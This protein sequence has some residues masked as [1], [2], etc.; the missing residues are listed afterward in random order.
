MLRLP[1]AFVLLF[2][3][4]LTDDESALTALDKLA[5]AGEINERAPLI[6][7]VQIQIAAPPDRVWIKLTD[8]PDWP[9]WGPEI[10]SASADMPL[11]LGSHLAWQVGGLTIHARIQLCEAGHRLAWT[12]VAMT[13]RAVHVWELRPA[14]GNQT[15]VTVNES[16]E[17]P[18]MRL[19]YSSKK[20]ARADE[21][22]LQA[23]K[24]AS[25][26]GTVR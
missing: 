9:K 16:M 25:E 21:D 3:L 26:D 24:R 2:C 19:L 4:A 8:V 17:G 18:M 7:H 5:A 22:W 6:S 15:L 23:L 11:H 14:A 1:L 12:G 13:A 10:K 20:L